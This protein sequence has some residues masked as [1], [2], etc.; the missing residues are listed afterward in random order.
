VPT[1]SSTMLRQR[2]EEMN[3]LLYADR[4]YGVV[5]NIEQL[6]RQAHEA[7]VTVER[8]VELERIRRLDLGDTEEIG[9]T[10]EDEEA[11]WKG[12]WAPVGEKMMRFRRALHE[13][14]DAKAEVAYAVET[15]GQLELALDELRNKLR[16]K[17]DAE[18]RGDTEDRGSEADDGR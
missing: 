13:Q 18:W 3:Q 1:I 10:D 12:E 11:A 14:M 16:D 9:E 15:S 2:R 5:A 6:L 4:L 7:L 8:L 17:F